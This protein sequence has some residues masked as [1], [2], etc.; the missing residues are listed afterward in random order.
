MYQGELEKEPFQ[1]F[2]EENLMSYESELSL[3]C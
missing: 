2:I 1:Q 3:V